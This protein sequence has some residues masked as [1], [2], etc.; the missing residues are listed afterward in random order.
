MRRSSRLARI[1]A[2]LVKEVIQMRRDRLTFAMIVGIPIIQLVLFGYAINTD[3]KRLPTGIVMADP[4]PVARALVAGMHSSGYFAIR[5][6]LSEAEARD[7][8]AEGALAFVVTVPAGFHRD[9]V[10]GLAPQVAIEAD[11]SDPAAS[12]NAIAAIPEILRRAL[13]SASEGAPLAPGVREAEVVI[14]RLYNPE[15]V[16]AYNIVPGLIGTILTMTTT[17]MTALALTRETERGTMENLLAM[18]VRPAEIMVGKILPYIGLGLLQVGVI[19]TA[20]FLLFRV[21]MEGSFLV[22]FAAVLLFLAANVTLG[23]TF[24]T[25]ARTQMQAMQMTFFFFLPSILLSGFMFPFRGMPRWAQVLG[26]LLPLTHFLRAVRGIMLK[27][28]DVLLILPHLW[29]V[30]AFLL[31]IGTVALLR[32]RRTLD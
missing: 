11:A 19:L 13:A 4:G 26:E 30:A 8:L 1:R 20:A 18:P 15:G 32:F 9:L 10:R 31:V 16:N 29:P 28:N 2:I 7:G 3:P 27:G 17:L 12:A 14:H 25:L 24:S 5:Q 21:P 6:V 22:L 23:Y